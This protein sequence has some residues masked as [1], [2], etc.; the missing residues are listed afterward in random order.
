MGLFDKLVDQ[1]LSAYDKI[2]GLDLTET[3]V[4][5]SQHKAPLGGEGTGPNPTDR[6][7]SGWKWSLLTDRAGIPIGWTTDGANRHDT[8]LFTAT[9]EP[10]KHRGLLND[11]ET[12]HLDRG[13]D[14][15]AVRSTCK[16]LGLDVVDHRKLPRDDHRNSPPVSPG[17]TRRSTTWGE[18]PSK[19]AVPM[20]TS[21]KGPPPCSHEE[22]TWKLTH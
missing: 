22:K 19:L 4:D 10:A 5:G 17:W 8:V 12:L 15:K 14:S 21:P 2:V 18:A 16:E 7:K 3:A 11:I 13:Y 9:L 6:G 20:P 1:A